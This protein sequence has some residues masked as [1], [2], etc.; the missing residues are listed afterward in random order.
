[1]KCRYPDLPRKRRSI[2]RRIATSLRSP[3]FPVVVRYN[4]LFPRYVLVGSE[5][6][7]AQV[8]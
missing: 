4:E 2:S 5:V 7:G 3:E 6:T 8:A 1:M